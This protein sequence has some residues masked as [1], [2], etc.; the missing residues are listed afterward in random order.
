MLYHLV[1]FKIPAST[2]KDKIL[3]FYSGLETL[4]SIKGVVSIQCGE[5]DKVCYAGYADR[6]KGYT[7]AL[8]VVLTDLRA[9]EKYDKDIHHNLI[10]STIIMPLIDKTA[11]NPVLAIDFPGQIPA[12]V[13]FNCDTS[14]YTKALVGVSVAAV[15]TFAWLKIH[16]RL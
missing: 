3:N 6:T 5:V 10:K 16:S 4:K 7:H 1:L 2:G 12:K 14:I 15:F 8:L 9:L 11:E 13:C